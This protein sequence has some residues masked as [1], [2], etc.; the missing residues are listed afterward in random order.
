MGSGLPTSGMW[1]SRRKQK[2][3][4]FFKNVQ[5]GIEF[6]PKRGESGHLS[7]FGLHHARF[8]ES[9]RAR[10]CDEKLP[11]F[12]RGIVT[13]S[14][15][16]RSNVLSELKEPGVQKGK[17]PLELVAVGQSLEN[18]GGFLLRHRWL[19]GLLIWLLVV[20]SRFYTI[21]RFGVQ[22][23]YM[24][25]FGEID[26]YRPVVKNDWAL[27]LANSLRPNNEHRIVLTR[28]TNIEL[29]LLD[30]K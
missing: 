10:R 19:L 11:R 16:P 28:W 20:E 22:E 3:R 15:R 24:D 1:T 30:A 6:C 26:D 9:V 29:F 17:R 25:S 8:R 21:K 23:P 12:A 4:K 13:E 5:S 2:F 27:L 18:C 7:D 14:S